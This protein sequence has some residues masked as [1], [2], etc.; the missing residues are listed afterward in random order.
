MVPRRSI[1]SLNRREVL[2]KVT[3]GEHHIRGPCGLVRGAPHRLIIEW[4]PCR[5]FLSGLFKF[6][7][8]KMY[9]DMLLTCAEFF[10]RCQAD[11][12]SPFPI[13]RANL[14]VRNCEKKV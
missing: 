6:I 5:N 1:V 2:G 10:G 12:S 11:R 9:D 3:S 14:V 8:V 13:G 4:I 7:T